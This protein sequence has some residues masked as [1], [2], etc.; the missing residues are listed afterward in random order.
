MYRALYESYERGLKLYNAVDFDDLIML[1][2][3][4]VP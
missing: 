4:P 1:P 3:P 2:I